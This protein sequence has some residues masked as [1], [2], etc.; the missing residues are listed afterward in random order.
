MHCIGWHPNPN[1]NPNA[2]HQNWC[3]T[4]EKL[5][6]VAVSLRREFAVSSDEGAP[7]PRVSH[8]NGSA[9]CIAPA[10][11]GG[12]YRVIVRTREL[13]TLRGAVSASAVP[14]SARNSANLVKLGV[15]PRDLVD[16]VAPHVD[17]SALRLASDTPETH[18]LLRKIDEQ[19]LSTSYKVGVLLSARGQCSEEELYNNESST[20]AFERFLDVLGERVLL[21]GWQ[22]YRGGLDTR[23]DTTG[24]HSVFARLPL[25]RQSSPAAPASNDGGVAGGGGVE[26]G[27]EVMFHVSTL[28]PFSPTN[29]QQLQRKRHIGNDMVTIVF[30]EA[31]ALPLDVAS[32]RSHFQH[33]FIVVRAFAATSHSQH[34]SHAVSSEHTPSHSYI[35]RCVCV[36]VQFNC[37]C[38]W[39]SLLRLP[40][41]PFHS[42]PFHVCNVQCDAACLCRMDV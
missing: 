37:I 35:Y 16:C 19:A 12:V 22:A 7:P 28:L 4:D 40:S 36:H 5:G 18:A 8:R 26:L 11:A 41:I 6:P 2:E 21:R 27:V 24:T 29:R 25:P 31:G 32:F 10:A 33:V 15:P 17:T 14:T 9:G 39:C 3:G 1:P 30:Q 23:A 20:P 13:A 38:S 42:L 34:Q